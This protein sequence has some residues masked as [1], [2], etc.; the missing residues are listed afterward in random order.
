MEELPR[1]ETLKYET[2]LKA[3]AKK[4]EVAEK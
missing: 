3:Q 2:L 4:I 1:N